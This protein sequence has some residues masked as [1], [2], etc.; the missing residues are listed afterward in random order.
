MKKC[1]VA[2]FLFVLIGFINC[3]GSVNWDSLGR[4]VDFG[5][6]WLLQDTIEDNLTGEYKQESYVFWSV[7]SDTLEDIL[8][9]VF[10]GQSI[11]L[12]DLQSWAERFNDMKEV[13]IRDAD[14]AV[15]Q[16]TINLML[17]YIP[18]VEWEKTIK[19][20]TVEKEVFD[21]FKRGFKSMKAVIDE[22]LL[23]HSYLEAAQ[24]IAEKIEIPERT[25]KLR[26]DYVR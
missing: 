8:L 24:S 11:H 9:P 5:V 21:F 12:N 26:F 13:P 15:L 4:V 6:E 18:T 2:L 23:K 22:G 10:E 20:G 19:E 16:D 1:L 7:V 25:L 3:G 17:S 14:I